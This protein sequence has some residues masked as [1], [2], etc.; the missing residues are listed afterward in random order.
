MVPDLRKHKKAF[1][2]IY[3]RKMTDEEFKNNA[4]S[5]VRSKS[6]PYMQKYEGEKQFVF[7]GKDGFAVADT[8]G[9]VRG[10]FHSRNIDK[11]KLNYNRVNE[12]KRI[13]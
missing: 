9:T 8:D 13:I 4:I 11:T 7:Y 2:K 3:D 10:Y 6:D 5:L 1:E 12:C